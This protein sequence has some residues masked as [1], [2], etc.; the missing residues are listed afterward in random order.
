MFLAIKDNYMDAVFVGVIVF[1]TFLVGFYL[2][3]FSQPYLEEE[4]NRFWRKAKRF[5]VREKV[6]FSSPS[7]KAKRDELTKDIE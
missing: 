2:G 5:G 1:I 6:N 3:R 7:Q 4:K